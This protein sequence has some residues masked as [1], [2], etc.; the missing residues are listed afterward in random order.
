MATTAI[1]EALLGQQGA[2]LPEAWAF[3]AVPVEC[4][5]LL[6]RDFMQRTSALTKPDTFMRDPHLTT[7]SMM[8]KQQLLCYLPQITT[9]TTI[10]HFHHFHEGR[11]S[12]VWEPH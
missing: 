3:F 2:G 11:V 7:C 10:N 8:G 1:A 12:R 5:N 6:R 4:C 9:T